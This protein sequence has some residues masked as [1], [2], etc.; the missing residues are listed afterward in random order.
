MNEYRWTTDREQYNAMV[1]AVLENLSEACDNAPC[2]GICTNCP[3]S[4]A[5]AEILDDYFWKEIK[6]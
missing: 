2:F 4:E 3:I 6:Q 1:D 5:R